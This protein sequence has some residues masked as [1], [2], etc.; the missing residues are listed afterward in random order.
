MIATYM[1]TFYEILYNV[2]QGQILEL[3]KHFDIP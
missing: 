1:D 2:L 3:N